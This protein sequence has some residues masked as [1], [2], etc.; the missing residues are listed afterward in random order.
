VIV[1]LLY[2][3]IVAL[4]LG[5]I[6]WVTTQ[7]PFLQP[8]AHIIRVICVVIFVIYVIYLLMGFLGVHAPVLTR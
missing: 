5:L 6:Y 2:L 3:V 4:V 8:F 7:I 1:A